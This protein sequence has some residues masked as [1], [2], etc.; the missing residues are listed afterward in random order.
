MKSRIVR[1]GDQQ[2][3]SGILSNGR[4]NVKGPGLHIFQP[5]SL[6]QQRPPCLLAFEEQ[7][8]LR[9]ATLMAIK[10]SHERS[11]LHVSLLLLAGSATRTRK[12]PTTTRGV[13]RKDV[14]CGKRLCANGDPSD[15]AV[16]ATANH[17]AFDLLSTTISVPTSTPIM[18]NRRTPTAPPAPA[19][20]SRLTISIAWDGTPA[21]LATAAM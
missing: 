9:S 17:S 11:S 4:R 6:V 12:A 18:S 15:S 3:F 16:S 2:Y 7:A 5:D 19:A 13:E 21:T 14:G 8:A 1:A 20:G 10:S